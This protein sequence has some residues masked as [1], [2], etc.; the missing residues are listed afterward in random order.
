M[1]FIYLSSL[2][3]ATNGNVSLVLIA[4][5]L[6]LFFSLHYLFLS[7][8]CSLYFFLFFTDSFISISASPPSISIYFHLNVCRLIVLA[9]RGCGGLTWF[10]SL[11]NV[12]LANS[13][14]TS[15]TVNNHTNPILLLH[16]LLLFT[17]FHSLSLSS[18]LCVVSFSDSS[19]L[20]VHLS[21]TVMRFSSTVSGLVNDVCESVWT[22]K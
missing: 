16:S 8:S 22:Q 5:V 1:A 9:G 13:L 4:S 10:F 18:P 3:R 14:I 7:V 15:T 20:V 21:L 17:L 6:P 2:S 12:C 11:I 19:M